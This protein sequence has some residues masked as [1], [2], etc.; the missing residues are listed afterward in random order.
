MIYISC[1]RF[2][3]DFVDEKFAEILMAGRLYDFQKRGKKTI[4]GDGYESSTRIYSS[5]RLNE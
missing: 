4:K 1:L 3:D 2:K 5:G